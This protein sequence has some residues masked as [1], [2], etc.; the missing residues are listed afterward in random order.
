MKLPV[1]ASVA[2]AVVMAVMGLAGCSGSSGGARSTASGSTGSA[3][4]APAPGLAGGDGETSAAASTAT[5]TATPTSTPTPTATPTAPVVEVAGDCPYI[6]NADV[7]QIEG[8]RVGHS[9]L[10]NSTP[11]GC[12]FYF[13]YDAKAI[14]F[15][16]TV[17]T[18]PTATSAFNAMVLSAKDHPELVT[19][20]DIGDGGS[21]AFLAPLQGVNTWQCSFTK[22]VHLI[23]AHT[24][25]PDPSFNARSLARSLAPKF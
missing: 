24:R 21:V 16:L 19:D 25:Q 4:S 13:A 2:A 6:S 1:R 14:V 9:V 22:G 3:G 11:V 20:T 8:D 15:E 17:T 7:Q 12:R 23:T 5:P 10:L 18:Y